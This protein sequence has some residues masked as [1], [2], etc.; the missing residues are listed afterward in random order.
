M[1]A[2]RKALWMLPLLAA[3]FASGWLA[4][5]Q[6][7]TGRSAASLL[8]QQLWKSVSAFNYTIDPTFWY[9]P[10]IPLLDTISGV[11]FLAGLLWAVLHIKE[12]ANATLVTWWA[13]AVLT[14]WVITE[15]PPSSMRLVIVAPALALLSG[16]G[17]IWAVDTGRRVLGGSATVWAAL[18]GLTLAAVAAL[19]LHHYFTVYTP[20]RVYGNPTAETT[21]ELARHLAQPGRECVVY[22]HGAPFIYWDFG[23]LRFLARD[24]PGVNVPPLDEAEATSLEIDVQRKACFVFVPER[25]GELDGVRARFPTGAEQRVYSEVDGRL[26]YVLFEVPASP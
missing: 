5:E 17:L 19:N 22:F 7:I 15:N 26:L 4:Q 23:T 10:G 18:S 11:L 14:G 24:V 2:M 16:F 13:L 12:P 20:T 25:I 21:T 6:V 3:A 1:T 8:L 9:R